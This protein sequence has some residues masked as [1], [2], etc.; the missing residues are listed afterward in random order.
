M[1]YIDFQ[2]EKF[3]IDRSG[4][5][6][7]TLP[8]TEGL[9]VLTDHSTVGDRKDRNYKYYSKHGNYFFLEKSIA[10]EKIKK[11]KSLF[12][13]LNVRENAIV[14][15]YFAKRLLVF[16]YRNGALIWRFTSDD[17]EDRNEIENKINE[18]DLP[19]SN[20][21]EIYGAN[22]PIVKL[23]E[24]VESTPAYR[25]LEKES[26][27]NR[28]IQITASASLVLLSIVI[29]AVLIL[30]GKNMENDLESVEFENRRIKDDLKTE[31]LARLPLYLD[32]VNIPLDEVIKTLSF[33]EGRKYSAINA[34]SERR[35][36]TG[37]VTLQN[38]EEAYRIKES[39]KDARVSIRGGTIEISFTRAV[40]EDTG[41]AGRG[42]YRR[43]FDL[44]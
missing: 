16:S 28:L 8:S 33:L 3:Y 34:T 14:G 1:I 13:T 39:A 30:K 4:N 2:K 27:R 38:A 26:K 35:N 23:W 42:N 17:I 31:Y 6:G 11:A 43:L 18:L 40:E 44:Q 22:I 9:A 7:G 41:P 36:I 37:T 10:N 32:A 15:I 21:T 29:W 19:E 24:A 12:Q 5:V 25:D 20:V